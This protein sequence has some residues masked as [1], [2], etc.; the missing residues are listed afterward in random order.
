MPQTLTGIVAVALTF[1]LAG[2]VKG[3]AGM[4][5]PTVAMGVLGIGMAPKEAAALVVIPSLVTN[6]WQ[7]S[8]GHQRLRVL[9]RT[10]PMLT[11]AAVMT[12]TAAGLLT[13]QGANSGAVWLGAALL[14]YAAATLANV[15][16]RV[17]RRHEPWLSPAVGASTGII[18]GATGVFVIPAVPYLQALGFERDELV[19]ALGLSFTVST[20][21]LAGGLA[22]HGAFRVGAL[23]ASTLCTLP[24]LAGMGLGQWIR[25]RVNARTFRR[26]FLL[27][28]LGIG[29]ELIGHGLF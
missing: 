26:L 5:L 7:Y 3:V 22:S 19:Q 12:W 25:S 23:E 9:S 21:A 8:S 29:V 1:M 10:W 6:V 14:A 11:A 16:I 27:C 28:L 17:P 13:R 4:G 2:L 18:T 24:A 20:L 15:R